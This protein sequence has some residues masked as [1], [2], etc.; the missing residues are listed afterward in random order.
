M[1]DLGWS[2]CIGR[3]LSTFMMYGGVHVEVGVELHV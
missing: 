1:Y 3:G 2:T